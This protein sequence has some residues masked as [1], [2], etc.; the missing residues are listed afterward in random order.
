MLL[1]IRSLLN[2]HFLFMFFQSLRI[3]DRAFKVKEIINGNECGGKI[4]YFY[5]KNSLWTLG[6][7]FLRTI[8]PE[9]QNIL[10][11][12]KE[13]NDEKIIEELGIKEGQTFTIFSSKARAWNKYKTEYQNLE[14]PEINRNLKYTG[15]HEGI[16]V[17]GNCKNERIF[18][19]LRKSIAF[20]Y[21]GT[22]FDFLYDLKKC[23]CRICG[24]GIRFRKLILKNCWWKENSIA[25]KDEKRKFSSWSEVKGKNK[26]SIYDSSYLLKGPVKNRRQ[27][28]VRSRNY[29]LSKSSSCYANEFCVI[30]Q[31]KKRSPYY[32]Q[33][34]CCGNVMHL[35]CTNEFYALDKYVSCPICKTQ[36][37]IKKNLKVTFGNPFKDIKIVFT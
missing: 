1:E 37:Q 25:Y 27:I 11:G 14:Y 28:Q 20:H 34:K 8:S 36:I 26:V 17:L 6:I 24:S 5:P 29:R 16:I 21:K 31:N 35:C 10:A 9:T 19:K 12:W 23:R 22:E 30:C 7:K 13:T 3:G 32:F 18:C 33:K 4:D 2:S 15:K